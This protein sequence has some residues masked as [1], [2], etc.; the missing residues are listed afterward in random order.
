M[1]V[2]V[3]LRPV[4]RFVVVALLITSAAPTYAQSRDLSR[5]LP[6]HT[7]ALTTGAT[8]T[9]VDALNAVL[10]GAHFAGLSNDGISYGGT[11]YFSVGRAMI[12]FDAARTTFGEEG[13][14]NGRTDDLSSTQV[15]LTASYALVS[16][17]RVAVFPSIGVGFGRI[18]L[19][20]RDRAGGATVGAAQPTFAEV[21]TAPGTESNLT[22]D[23]L[24]FSVGGGG[25]YLILRNTRDDFGIVFGVR[26]GYMIAPNRTTWTRNAQTV[27]AG[28]DASA[29]GPFLRIV[30]GV[31]GR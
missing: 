29:G 15:L 12:G 5:E 20:L 23:H 4:S 9:S 31:G 14:D 28:P 24:L 18:Q 10:I 25:D 26:A 19:A 2:E 6:F 21:A 7:I 27:I 8:S 22:G 11:G 3:R 30:V 1:G 16:T 13:L 17:G